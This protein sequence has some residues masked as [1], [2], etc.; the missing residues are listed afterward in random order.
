MSGF[1]C[2]SSKKQNYTKEQRTT[3]L[4]IR[5]DK[6]KHNFNIC[7]TKYRHAP[8]F[9][10]RVKLDDKLKNVS[11]SIAYLYFISMCILCLHKLTENTSKHVYELSM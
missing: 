1:F 8:K 11:V 9:E 4:N 6:T 5:R 3:M 10:E 2:F 7:H